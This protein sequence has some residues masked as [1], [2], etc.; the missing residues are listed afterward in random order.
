MQKPLDGLAARFPAQL[1]CLVMNGENEFSARIIG[2]AESLLGIT[3]DTNPRIVCADG[4]D[5]EIG[6]AGRTHSGE[7][8]GVCGVAAKNNAEAICFDYVSVKTAKHV[9]ADTRAPVIHFKRCDLRGPYL[10]GSMPAQFMHARVAARPQEIGSFA[11]SHD[12][13]GLTFE[14]SQA[15]QIEVIHMRVREQNQIDSRKFA[16]RRGH[17]DKPFDADGERSKIDA[18]APAEYGIRENGV[19]VHLDEHGGV[20]IPGGMQTSI[21]PE[22]G[23]RVI[24]RWNTFTRIVFRYFAQECGRCAAKKLGSFR[25]TGYALRKRDCVSHTGWTPSQVGLVQDGTDHCPHRR[26]CN[27]ECAIVLWRHASARFA[28]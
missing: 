27:A 19:P 3:M 23:L 22:P 24:R 15:R 8:I 25:S 16:N 21:G 17:F 20:S 6:S 13:S 18:Y 2:H 14:L 1:E 4:H 9:A 26:T 28:V 12:M 5:G 11:S 7:T 10:H